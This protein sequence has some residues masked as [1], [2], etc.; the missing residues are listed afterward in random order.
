MGVVA[1]GI[2]ENQEPVKVEPLLKRIL[3]LLGKL[4]TNGGAD[5]EEKP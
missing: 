5:I 4:K 2:T 1:I 3:E